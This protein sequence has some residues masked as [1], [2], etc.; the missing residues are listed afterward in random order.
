MN[1]I[2]PQADVSKLADIEV[3]SRGSVLRV[4]EHSMIDAF[5]KIKFAGG[6]G[7]IVIGT[8][9][10]VN[11]GAVL[12]SGN[13]ITIGNFVMIAAN[14]TFAPTNHEFQRRDIPMRNQGFRASKGGI[15]IADDVWIGANCVVLDGAR[16]G[17]GSIIAANSVVN[18]EIEEY[19]IYAGTPAKRVGNRPV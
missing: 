16:I 12:Y 18:G 2:S 13:G 8:N 14:C 4:G 19:G 1:D 15:I 7:D 17:R 3:S 9:S 11:S 10:Y 6:T 5:V